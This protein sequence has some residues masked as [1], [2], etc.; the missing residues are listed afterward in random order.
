M[1]IVRVAHDRENPY[2]M[3]NRE[4]LWDTKLSA[5]ATC[6]WVRLLSRPNNWRVSVTELSKS[7]EWSATTVYRVLKELQENGYCYK[8]QP[9]GENGKFAQVEYFVFEKRMTEQEIQIILPL[10]QKPLSGEPLSGKWCTNNN[11]LT[12]EEDKKRNRTP[13]KSNTPPNPLKGE[14]P[15]NAGTSFASSSNQSKE[16]NTSPGRPKKPKP[17]SSAAP[18]SPLGIELACEL[19]RQVKVLLPDS[20]EPKIESWAKQVD[21]MMR[22]DIIS[23]VRMRKVLKYLPTDV[24][25]RRN[26][27]SIEKLRDHFETLELLL[28]EKA[29]LSQE[30]R[31]GLVSKNRAKFYKIK[32]FIIKSRSLA[33]KGNLEVHGLDITGPRGVKTRL[34]EPQMLSKIATWFGIKLEAGDDD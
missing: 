29:P 19:R 10:C 12:K 15:A 9:K 7:C 20:K 33:E 32:E 6:L 25:W 30:E 34:D 8:F 4:S 24:F 11:E 2:V 28:K 14:V 5:M 31:E 17:P 22:L 3:I 21:D 23:E 18:P 16:E 27:R 13:P 26:V 1:S